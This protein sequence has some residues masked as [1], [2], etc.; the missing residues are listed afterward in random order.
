MRPQVRPFVVEVKKRRAGQSRERSIWG[1]IDLPAFSDEAEQ[2]AKIRKPAI[3]AL[4]DSS[5]ATVVP[6]EDGSDNARR[7]RYM[8]DRK[9]DVATEVGHDAP[10]AVEQSK[11]KAPRTK[12]AKPARK[13]SAAKAVAE[14]AAA[15]QPSATARV[16]KKY[17]AE[18][19][20]E[21]LKLIELSIGGGQGIKDATRK[22]GVSEQT[23][24][25]W[26]RA[27]APA[28][29]GEDLED[30]LAL[31]EENTR[32]KALLAERLRKENAELKKKLGLA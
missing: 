30:L 20:A 24:Y 10:V 6:V 2:G 29:S 12:G 27:A 22:A 32:L 28:A 13:R 8:A 25:Q 3:P 19:R 14:V 21:K 23:Y 1:G 17:S 31:E 9:D 26:K 5:S 4:V 11:A 7:E 15:D 18:E 16:R